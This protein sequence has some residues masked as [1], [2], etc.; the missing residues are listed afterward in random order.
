[1]LTNLLNCLEKEQSTSYRYLLVDP[2]KAV[3]PDEPLSLVNINDIFPQDDVMAVIRPDLRHNPNSC[4]HLILLAK[5]N[6]AI[7]PEL[8]T[9]TLERANKEQTLYKHYICGWISSELDIQ[10]LADKMINLGNYLGDLLS[11]GRSSFFAFYEHIRLQLLKESLSIESLL[12]EQFNFVNSYT[13]INY[14]GQLIELISNNHLPSQ[15]LFYISAT[16]L[17]NAL[18]YQQNPKPIY[19]LVKIWQ[20]NIDNLPPN[21]IFCSAEKL[22]HANH[23]GLTS[24][25]DRLIYSL[26]SLIYHVDLINIE[27]IAPH[28]M[29]AISSPGSLKQRLEQLDSNIWRRIIENNQQP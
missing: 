19:G 13:Y 10:S 7:E 9:L 12:S 20:D 22:L 29:A 27:S 17:Q 2:L 8:L 25:E 11:P 5:P 14:Y 16:L 26:Y 6:Q 28:V 15:D 4:P 21:A 1:M 24:L 3:R 23:L 18:Q